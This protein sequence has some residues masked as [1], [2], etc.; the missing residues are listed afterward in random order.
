MAEIGLNSSSIYFCSVSVYC[1][2]CIYSFFNQIV[3]YQS[4]ITNTQLD[5]CTLVDITK[6]GLDSMTNPSLKYPMISGTQSRVSCF[7]MDAGS[8]NDYPKYR[9]EDITTYRSY[10][11][12]LGL[13]AKL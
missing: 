9:H 3:I 10:R 8:H 2:Y 1:T 5:S 4:F 7:I 6:K 12:K 11:E 13:E